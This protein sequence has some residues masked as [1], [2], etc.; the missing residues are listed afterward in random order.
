MGYEKK[1]GGEAANNQVHALVSPL[2]VSN[3]ALF[4]CHEKQSKVK[5]GAPGNNIKSAP[6][7]RQKQIT[8]TS[9]GGA[10]AKFVKSGRYYRNG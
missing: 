9:S 6:A 4:V 7:C 10:E 2:T 3:Y 5:K 1:K 8:V